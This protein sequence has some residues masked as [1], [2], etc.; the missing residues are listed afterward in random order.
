MT[1]A[2]APTRPRLTGSGVARMATVVLT[3]AATAAIYFLA[4][5]TPAVLRAWLYYGGLLA[6]L[7]LAMAAAAAVFPQVIETVN[8]RGHLHKDVKTWD[9]VFGLAYTILLLVEPAVAGWDV[10]RAATFDAGWPVTALALTATVAAYAF[11][12]WAMV[13][14]PH[15]ETGGR[16]QGERHHTVISSGP[17]RLVRHPF[18]VA[19]IVTQLVYPVAVGSPTAFVPGIAIAALFVWRT[20]REDRTLRSELEGYEAYT[21]R[22]RYRLVPGVW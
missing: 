17:Y 8:A 22:T 12:H 19:L 10:R 9:K 11:V 13:V 3:L 5:G 7:L 16:V 14:N 4:A 2:A 1:D 15:A 20:G 6:Y 21:E 18:Y